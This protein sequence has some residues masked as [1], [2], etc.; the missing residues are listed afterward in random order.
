MTFTPGM[1]VAV[2][3]ITLGAAALAA[4]L[5]WMVPGRIP[6]PQAST[7]AYQPDATDAASAPTHTASG[8]TQ[9][10]KTF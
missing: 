3:V 6:V 8:T 10:R 1:K 2:F 7:P 4:D 9:E 5:I